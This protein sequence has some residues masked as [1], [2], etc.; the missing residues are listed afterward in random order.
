MKTF[1]LIAGGALLASAG[2]A[3]AQPAP[4]PRPDHNAPRTRQQ[5]IEQVDQ[6][7]ARLDL[8]NDGRVT[9]EEARQAGEQRRA[10]RREQ[11]AGQAF[12]RLDANRD[13]NVT[14]AEFDQARGQLRAQREQRRGQRPHRMMIRRMHR[15]GGPGGPHGP[16][17]RGHGLFGEQG[18]ITREQMRERALAHFDRLDANRD[19]TVTVEERQQARQ[20][21]RERIRERVR[22]RI[23]QR[24]DP[25]Q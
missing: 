25:A 4:T 16:G 10:Q 13:G 15:P 12:A 19:G 20:Q 1:S 14:R 5:V 22:T 18:F 6:R 11:R 24:N 8:N 7:F 23:E 2:L 3:L 17:M 9:P 21:M